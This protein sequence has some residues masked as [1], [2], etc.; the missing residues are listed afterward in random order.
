MPVKSDWR[1]DTHVRTS[2]PV[3]AESTWPSE[4]TQPNT[5]PRSTGPT[6]PP[7]SMANVR[8]GDNMSGYDL[9]GLEIENRLGT[10]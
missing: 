3:A 5:T 7:G 8:R 4:I 6:I 10:R 1:R 9:H 2:Y